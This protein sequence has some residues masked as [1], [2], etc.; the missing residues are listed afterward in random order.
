MHFALLLAATVTGT[1][2]ATTAIR[3]TSNVGFVIDESKNKQSEGRNGLS[4][5]NQ[6]NFIEHS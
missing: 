6:G 3:V 4:P 1:Q 5:I 2:T